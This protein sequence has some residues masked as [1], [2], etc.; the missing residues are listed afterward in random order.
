[1]GLEHMVP[2]KRSVVKNSQVAKRKRKPNL[3]NFV[4][5]YC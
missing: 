1:M 3:L 4:L 2:K 5:V